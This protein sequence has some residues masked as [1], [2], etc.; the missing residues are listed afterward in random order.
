MFNVILVLF[1]YVIDLDELRYCVN[2][3][4]AICLMWMLSYVEI[5]IYYICVN[6]VDEW[7]FLYLY[8]RLNYE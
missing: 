4:C 6:P 7:D 5:L 2:Y 1:D 3:P 8:K